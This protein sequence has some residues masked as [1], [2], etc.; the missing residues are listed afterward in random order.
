VVDLEHVSDKAPRATAKTQCAGLC[1]TGCSRSFL[2]SM[3]TF[4]EVITLVASK[5]KPLLVAI[6]GLPLSGKTTLALR[7]VERLG[8]ECLSLDDFMKPEVEWPSRDRPSFPFEYIRFSEFVTAVHALAYHR[9]CSF[10]PYD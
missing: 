7:L 9:R 10:H 1:R 3:L 4:D 8:A 2:G 6:D 5:P